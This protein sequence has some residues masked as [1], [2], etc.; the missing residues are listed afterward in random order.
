MVQNMVWI[1]F[2]FMFLLG[3][4]LTMNVF[5]TVKLWNLYF[6]KKEQERE[7]NRI[8]DSEN[9]INCSC[10]SMHSSLSIPPQYGAVNSSPICPLRGAHG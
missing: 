2:G 8:K 6:E 10:C 5:L 3:I 4:S 1:I 9:P 7:K